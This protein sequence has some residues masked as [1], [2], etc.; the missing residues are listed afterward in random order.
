MNYLNN[1]PEIQILGLESFFERQNLEKNRLLKTQI[2]L[3]TNVFKTCLLDQTV[4]PSI[5]PTASKLT[6]ASVVKCFDKAYTEIISSRAWTQI[7][8]SYKYDET[9]IF[10]TLPKELI[11]SIFQIDRQINFFDKYNAR[12][13][14]QGTAPQYIQQILDKRNSDLSL[15]RLS[16]I[17]AQIKQKKQD[18]QDKCFL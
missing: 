16:P 17:D 12:L 13:A 1:L 11:D 10:C 9:S 3:Q 15:Q 2:E 5:A 4:A 6:L 18:E 14:S 8:A 7:L